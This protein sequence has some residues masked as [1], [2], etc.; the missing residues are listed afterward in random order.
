M[1]IIYSETEMLNRPVRDCI[2]I[3]PQEIVDL[4]LIGIEVANY[5]SETK[6]IF[7]SEVQLANTMKTNIQIKD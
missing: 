3:N 4:G 6:Y 2:R 1:I 5:S 7:S